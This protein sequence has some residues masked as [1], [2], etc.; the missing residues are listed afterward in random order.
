MFDFDN[1]R[2]LTPTPLRVIICLAYVDLVRRGG[3]HI[4]SALERLRKRGF[5]A[6]VRSEDERANDWKIFLKRVAVDVNAMLIVYSV[7]TAIATIFG[8]ISQYV[9]SFAFLSPIRSTSS[10]TARFSLI[11]S[12]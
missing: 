10:P 7:E 4:K 1:T 5:E 6:I 12:T 3:H 11:R 9:Y 2:R 8:W